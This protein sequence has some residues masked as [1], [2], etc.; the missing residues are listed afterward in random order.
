SEVIQ[1]AYSDFGIKRFI[2]GNTG[3]QMGGWFRREVNSLADLSGLRMRIPGVGGEIMTRLG[4]TVQVLAGGDIFPALERGAIDATEWVGPF[5][6][7]KLGFYQIAPYY[8]MPGW[9]EP[10]PS[11][12]FLMN[13]REW[14]RLPRTYQEIVEEVCVEAN[15]H[16]L[17]RF[18]HENPI[19]L[20][21]L[22]QEHGVQLRVFP[23]DFMEAAWRE[24]NAYLEEQASANPSFRKV[25]DSF[26][27]FRDRSFPYFAGNEQHY[28]RFA[29]DKIKGSL[30]V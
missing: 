13:Q 11:E 26:K 16:M 8:Y 14:D 24:S 19:A 2:C 18:D 28:A 20:E 17:T 23:D 1:E 27:T 9:W 10:G 5:D 22:V 30:N 3:C 25:Y 12:S 7:L 4:A 15:H 21:T 6:D 29:F